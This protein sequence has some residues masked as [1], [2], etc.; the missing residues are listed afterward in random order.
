MEGVVRQPTLKRL[1][2]SGFVGAFLF[3][4]VTNVTFE[5]HVSPAQNYKWR[6]DLRLIA[7]VGF[8]VV[9][10]FLVAFRQCLW[11]KTRLFSRN[12]INANQ[13]KI[14]AET[15]YENVRLSKKQ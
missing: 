7:D 4:V 1:P 15:L 14:I 6:E 11:L 13:D 2:I 10:Q 5:S 3:Q 9:D 12:T 8:P